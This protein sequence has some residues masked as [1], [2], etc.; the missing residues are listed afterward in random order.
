MAIRFWSIPD[1]AL[2]HTIQ[3]HEKPVL[4][5]AFNPDGTQLATGSGDNSL[6]LWSIPA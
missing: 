2:L 4:A 3:A 6:R 1:G 5:V